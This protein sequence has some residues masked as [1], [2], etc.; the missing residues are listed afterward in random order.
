MVSIAILDAVQML[1]WERLTKKRQKYGDIA[2]FNSVKLTKSI[3]KAWQIENFFKANLRKIGVNVVLK[4]LG[5]ISQVIGMHP[6]VS[7]VSGLRNHKLTGV[8]S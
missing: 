7:S 2:G 8:A 5:I 3:H 1:H 4:I 6:V